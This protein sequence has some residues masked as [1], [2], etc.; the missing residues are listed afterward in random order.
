MAAVQ[1]LDVVK[2]KERALVDSGPELEPLVN[3]SR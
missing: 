2:L 3:V 1:K